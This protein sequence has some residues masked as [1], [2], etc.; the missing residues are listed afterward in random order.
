MA[1]H[2]RV[3]HRA[4]DRLLFDSAEEVCDAEEAVEHARHGCARPAGAGGWKG[5]EM[6]ESDA[7]EG[8]A[9]ARTLQVARFRDVI[10]FAMFN[11]ANF[12]VSGK[13]YPQNTIVTRDARAAMSFFVSGRVRSEIT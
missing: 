3:P 4:P 5:K 1:E 12:V 11:F 9:D 8:C 6:D 10:S 13:L 7:V 2:R